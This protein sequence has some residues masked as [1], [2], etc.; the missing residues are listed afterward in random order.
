MQLCQ[1]YPSVAL[2]KP[3][4]IQPKSSQTSNLSP[5]LIT[6]QYPWIIFQPWVHL[7][8]ILNQTFLKSSWISWL[9]FKTVRISTRSKCRISVMWAHIEEALL[10]EPNLPNQAQGRIR[11]TPITSPPTVSVCT[12][13]KLCSLHESVQNKMIMVK[14]QVKC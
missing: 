12:I 10:E 6:H 7:S 13:S 2:N 5:S 14:P 4:S 11:L 9:S 3:T 8:T 1:E